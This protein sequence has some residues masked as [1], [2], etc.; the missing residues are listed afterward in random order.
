MCIRDRYQRRVRGFPSSAMPSMRLLLLVL[1]AVLCAVA[2]V[3]DHDA[4]TPIVML[5]ENEGLSGMDENVDKDLWLARK[6][7][8]SA[9]AEDLEIAR[10]L[11]MLESL[12]G[13]K[14]AAVKE[15]K[16]RE[17]EAKEATSAKLKE[18]AKHKYE[19]AKKA[20]DGKAKRIEQGAL[21]A[22]TDAADAVEKTKKLQVESQ[23][24][25]SK[26]KVAAE[27]YQSAVTAGMSD[28]VQELQIAAKKAMEQAQEAAR[29][30]GKNSQNAKV[31][32]AEA[33]RIKEKADKAMKL[34]RESRA[35]LI[36]SGLT[37]VSGPIF[38]KMKMLCERDYPTFRLEYRKLKM[39]PTYK[40]FRWD[41][42]QACAKARDDDL[43]SDYSPP[44]EVQTDPHNPPLGPGPYPRSHTHF[45]VPKGGKV[46]KWCSTQYGAV[47]CSM[48]EKAKAAGLLGDI[49]P[50]KSKQLLLEIGEE[51]FSAPSDIELV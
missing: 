2:A 27:E 40:G 4:T 34:E 42:K 50:N 33:T 1:G 36:E 44:P 19:V 43:E 18:T 35:D 45:A 23:A 24:L 28:R 3:H 49:G 21:S 51:T 25:M 30:A 29:A 47:P 32:L 31:A 12:D 39:S 22:Q 6:A 5:D 38:D 8:E 16:Q 14:D 17:I 20:I 37:W 15:A 9:D 46:A 26:A 48:L 7:Q 13:E 10:L 11:A 41:I